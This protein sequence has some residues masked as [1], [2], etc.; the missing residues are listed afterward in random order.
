MNKIWGKRTNKI[1]RIAQLLRE[2]SLE[3]ANKQAARAIDMH[4]QNDVNIIHF[5][6]RSGNPIMKKKKVE[7]FTY[8]PR[9]KQKIEIQF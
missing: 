5:L 8:G 4:P 3:H 1:Y 2:E 6:I 7:R 9:A